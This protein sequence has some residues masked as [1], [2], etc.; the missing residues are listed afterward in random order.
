MTCSSPQ[1]MEHW[2]KEPEVLK[3]FAVH[4]TTGEVVPDALLDKLNKARSFNQG[5]DTIEYVYFIMIDF[6]L[7]RLIH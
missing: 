3:E 1:L 2:L 6:D 4:H 7:G 5:F